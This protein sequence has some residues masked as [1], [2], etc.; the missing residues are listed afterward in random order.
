MFL[1]AGLL[2]GASLFWLPSQSAAQDDD[3]PP[4]LVKHLRNELKAKD[5]TRREMALLDIATLAHCRD[6]CTVHLESVQGKQIRIENQTGTGSV[7]DLDALI[8]DL[9]ENYRQG[10]ADGHRLLALSA[11]LQIGNEK[12]LERLVEEES[13]QSDQVKRRTQQGLATF[14][15]TKY[16]E[17]SERAM[18]TRRLS[19]DDV[20]RAKAYRM[21]KSKGSN[22]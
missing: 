6:S 16:P 13:R 4:T 15:L 18:R 5:A 9:L 11:L 2:L 7:V 1:F 14:Y 17:L 22:P 20:A 8:P 3:G 21:R 19:L 10:P 12:A